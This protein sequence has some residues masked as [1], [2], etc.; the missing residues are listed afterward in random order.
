MNFGIIIIGDEILSGK[1]ADKHLPKAIELLGNRG[2]QV[3]ALAGV[4]KTVIRTARKYLQMLE[5]ASL[6][7]GG[8]SDLFV[9]AQAPPEAEPAV[10]PLRE[11]FDQ[12][13]PDDLSPRDALELLY[14]LKNL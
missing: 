9:A 4:P 1:R 3:A 5:D 13:N 8:Q 12:V 2:L 11:A 14:R 7:R 6:A 10:D